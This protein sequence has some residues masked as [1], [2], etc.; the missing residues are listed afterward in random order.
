MKKNNNTKLKPS[1]LKRLSKWWFL[2]LFLGVLLF[3]DGKQTIINYKLKTYGKCTKAIVYSRKKVGGKGKV[4][5][6]YSFEWNN[7]THYGSSTS[8]DKYRESENFFLKED[9]LITG[10]TITVVFLES[11][12]EI[13][14]SNSIVRK[15]CDCEKLNEVKNEKK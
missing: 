3:L 4:E 1:I 14:R 15:N 13:N 5:T 7:V 9:D 11:N 6:S 12:P 10:D 8:D 2:F